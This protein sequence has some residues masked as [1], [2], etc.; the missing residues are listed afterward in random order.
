MF[1]YAAYKNIAGLVIDGPIRD[2][3]AARK[4]AIPIYA[5]AVTPGGPYKEGPGEINVPISCGGI[6]VIPGDIVVMD[7]DGVIII[8][9]KDAGEILESAKKLQKAD[10]NKIIESGHGTADRHWVFE[11]LKQKEIEIIDGFYSRSI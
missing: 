9:L 5:S 11:K 3:V 10:Q 8:P 7:Q 4:M 1:C 6:S 2:A